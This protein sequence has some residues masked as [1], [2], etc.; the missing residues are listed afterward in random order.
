MGNNMA[1]S[2]PSYLLSDADYEAQLRKSYGDA[3]V[4]ALLPEQKAAIIA[5]MRYLKGGI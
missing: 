1:T 2:T 4:N 3:Y 5:A